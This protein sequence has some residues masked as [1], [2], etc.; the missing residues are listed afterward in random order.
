MAPLCSVN[1]ID[2][3]CVNPQEKVLH[4]KR[5]I[6]DG[7]SVVDRRR[8]GRK[9]FP[10]T[11]GEIPVDIKPGGGPFERIDHSVAVFIQLLKMVVV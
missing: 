10:L 4:H 3:P 11:V 9:S 7:E 6:S 8:T 1:E 5:E 2:C